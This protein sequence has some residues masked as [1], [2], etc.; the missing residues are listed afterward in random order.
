MGAGSGDAAASARNYMRHLRD[1][2]GCGHCHCLALRWLLF[3]CALQLALWQGQLMMLLSFW[4]I[5][6][7]LH[8]DE[9]I[10]SIIVPPVLLP[11]LQAAFPPLREVGQFTLGFLPAR[12]SANCPTTERR[13]LVEVL[14]LVRKRGL[15]TGANVVEDTCACACASWP[16]WALSI[17]HGLASASHYVA[18]RARGSWAHALSAMRR[19]GKQRRGR[20]PS[21]PSAQTERMA[22]SQSPVLLRATSGGA[23]LLSILAAIVTAARGLTPLAVWEADVDALFL[24]LFTL[25]LDYW[26]VGLC[27]QQQPDE[28]PPRWLWAHVVP[29]L[30]PT[31]PRDLHE[32]VSAAIGLPPYAYVARLVLAWA[33]MLSLTSAP[34]QLASPTANSLALHVFLGV[35]TAGALHAVQAFF[36]SVQED[37]ENWRWSQLIVRDPAHDR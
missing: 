17:L 16:S 28:H 32:L 33:G 21:R 7:A 3:L 37:F 34:I 1:A 31:L 18:A 9:R 25:Q 29:L 36:Q 23:V 10:D 14:G 24:A 12:L 4:P 20:R 26:L 27:R 5:R 15:V 8:V 30:Q 6:A 13:H 2:H 11:A 19:N 35:M 22:A